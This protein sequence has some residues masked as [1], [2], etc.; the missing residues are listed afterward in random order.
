MNK[1]VNQ[2]SSYILLVIIAIGAMG[3]L[4][5]IIIFTSKEFRLNSCLFY[6]LCST[7]FDSFY[8]LISGITRLIND[9]YLH[10]K[11]D[12]S[13]FYC[14]CRTYFVVILRTLSTTFLMLSS[15]DRCL[16]TSRRRKW[17]HFSRRDLAWRMVL[18]NII[19]LVIFNS[20]ILFLFEIERKE[21]NIF[22]CVP[23]IGIYRKFVSIYFFLSNP[24][25]FYTIMFL[26]T[27]ITL[28]QIRTTRYRIKFLH[29]Q[30]RKRHENVD[31]HLITL[32]FIQIGLGMLLTFFRSGFLFYTL[33][34]SHLNKNLLTYNL[35][36]F[37]D[38]ISLLIYYM[39]FAKSFFV[40]ILTS[41]LIHIFDKISM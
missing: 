37:F 12:Q 41:P 8:L 20:H 5:N 30:N 39:N 10:I 13:L 11:F 23:R 2:I 1:I 14:K 36:L 27:I 19:F 33:C 16:S 40:N 35:E 28:L 25:L 17:H 22:Q 21:M 7:I 38:K 15:I 26:S 4:C 18:F 3:S 32:M 6:F 31:R 29:R 34:K 24:F 9:H